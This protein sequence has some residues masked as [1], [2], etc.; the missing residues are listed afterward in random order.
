MSDLEHGFLAAWR[1]QYP[2]DAHLPEREYLFAKH[3]GRK[4]RFDFA[5]PRFKVAVEMEGGGGRHHTFS[6]AHNDAEK[7]NAATAM[8]WRILRFTAK[9]MRE[10]RE[11][12]K[13]VT[14][15]LNLQG[16]KR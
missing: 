1:E 15:V 2:D 13:L 4:W 6:G 10:P 11:V 16:I 3:I 5:W 14:D 12:V 7:Y 9:H 8:G